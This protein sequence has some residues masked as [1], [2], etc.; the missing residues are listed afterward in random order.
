M[1]EYLLLIQVYKL[2]FNV[3]YI[4]WGKKNLNQKTVISYPDH[5]LHLFVRN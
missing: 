3:T 5:V 4:L 1:F 2:I